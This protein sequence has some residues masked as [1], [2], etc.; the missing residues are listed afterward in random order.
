MKIFG[1][2]ILIVLLGVGGCVTVDNSTLVDADSHGYANGQYRD[3]RSGK[4]CD[5]GIFGGGAASAAANA[6]SMLASSIT[7]AASIATG[8]STG[9]SKSSSGGGGLVGLRVYPAPAQGDPLPFARSI[10]MINYSKKLTK[11]SYD[12]S[13]LVNYEFGE[14][15]QK[16]RPSSFG[17]Q[18]V[19]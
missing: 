14:P 19:Q 3:V 2:L 15:T 13:G 17:H 11:V 4:L 1:L 16:S 5:F 9:S 12:D 10:A 7:T 6:N 18:P 8:N